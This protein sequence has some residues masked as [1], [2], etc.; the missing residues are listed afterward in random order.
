MTVGNSTKDKNIRIV[1]RMKSVKKSSSSQMKQESDV[2]KRYT[3]TYKSSCF[4]IISVSVNYWR[5]N[6]QERFIKYCTE[7]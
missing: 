1:K 3:A 6:F 7:I 2:E 4:E 5:K